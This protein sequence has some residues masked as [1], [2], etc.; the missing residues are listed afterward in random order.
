MN[1]VLRRANYNTGIYKGQG[2]V[3]DRYGY[4]PRAM[5]QPLAE[6]LRY[7]KWA[8]MS[9]VEACRPL[10]D[11]ALDAR[12]PGVSGTIRELLMHL[13]GG[14]KTSALRTKGR[15]NEGELTRRSV[16]PGFDALA[17]AARQSAD[18]LISIA[19]AME[20][21]SDVVLP[22][23]GKSYRFPKSFFL[24]AAME[25]GV[26]HRTEIK[27]GLGSL[28]IETSD[29]DGWFYARAAGYGSEVEG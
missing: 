6:M 2:D 15:Q 19:E 8:T 14:Q 28:G 9:L 26:E 25:H 22:Y 10:T 20:E 5:N 3:L 21:D 4:N 13:V 23:L 27:V 1:S 12:P 18:E 29:L 7:N 16:W 11:S 17:D 24:V